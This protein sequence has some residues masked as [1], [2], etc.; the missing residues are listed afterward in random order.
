MGIFHNLFLSLWEKCQTVSHTLTKIRPCA[1]ALGQFLS[2]LRHFLANIFGPKTEA[3]SCPI[4]FF[5]PPGNVGLYFVLLNALKH[6]HHHR[7]RPHCLRRHHH[8]SRH[9]HRHHQGR[10]PLRAD[11]CT[12][13]CPVLGWSSTAA[14][15]CS[16]KLAFLCL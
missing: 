15:K 2:H 11:K 9:H 3:Y 6:H 16:R 1:C 14:K 12:Q 7:R 4:G 5:G 13:T 8:L 10:P